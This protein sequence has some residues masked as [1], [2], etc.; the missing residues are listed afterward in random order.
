MKNKRNRKILIIGPFPLPISGVSL[1]NKVVK[2]ILIESPNFKVRTINTSFNK[3]DEKLGKLTLRKLLFYLALNF[4]V[5]KVFTNDIIYITPGQTFY[6]ITKYSLFI[7]LTALLK[8]EIIIHVHGNHLRYEY[9]SLN[10]IKKKIF[11]YLLSKSTKG[12]VLSESLKGNMSLFIKE[13]NIY[14]LYNFAEDYLVSTNEE[15]RTDR[16]R[17]VFLSN[18]MIEKG[19]LELLE[20]LEMLEEQNIDY[21]AKIAGNIEVANKK[22]FITIFKNL[23]FT[24]YLGVV[25]GEQKKELLEWSNVFVLPT[26]YKME[27]Q[28]ISIIE[29]MATNN[30]IITTK[31]AGIMD[32]IQEK[33]GY[34][35]EKRSAKSIA[36]KLKFISENK[37]V[38]A[39]ISGRNK[40]LFLERFTLSH[41]KNNFIKIMNS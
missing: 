32:I 22:R 29:A 24:E 13:E 23:K 28:P 27:G 14:T 37:E 35:V 41:F 9:Q 33:N 8:K 26:H 36:D 30:V 6:G 3:F 7:L 15:I 21:E 12:I 34:F 31:L 17:I 1:A 38:I 4:Q 25:N 10:G 2:E 18:L 19:I 40:R 11:Y 20:A 5:F 16:L 39:S